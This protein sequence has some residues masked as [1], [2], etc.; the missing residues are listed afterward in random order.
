M[1]HQA[2]QLVAIQQ[3][4]DQFLSRP[5][6]RTTSSSFIMKRR[7]TRSIEDENTRLKEMLQQSLKR[8]L[9]GLSKIKHLQEMYQDLLYRT[10]SNGED[11]KQYQLNCPESPTSRGGMSSPKL[12]VVQESAPIV[13]QS[14]E[15]SPGN[16]KTNGGSFIF[17][18]QLSP[19]PSLGATGGGGSATSTLAP[20][21]I[22]LRDVKQE[23]EKPPTILKEV[24]FAPEMPS[25]DVK[26]MSLDQRALNSEFSKSD[27]QIQRKGLERSRS[28]GDEKINVRQRSGSFWKRRPRPPPE[29]SNPP[30]DYVDNLF[31]NFKKSANIKPDPLSEYLGLH[32]S[33]FCTDR[34]CKSREDEKY[35]DAVWELFQAE[36]KYLTKQLQPLEQVYKGFLEELHFHRV[37]EEAKIEKI[38]ANLS[39]L[40]ELSSSIANDL[41]KLFEGRSQDNVALPN[42][43]VLSFS[44]F[45]HKFNPVYKTFCTNFEQQRGYIKSLEKIPT[46][47][48]YLRLC[49]SS[50]SVQRSDI[51]DLLI[52]PMQHQCHYQLLLDNVLKHT[53]DPNHRAV[54][55]S[56]IKAFKVSLKELESAIAQQRCSLELLELSEMIY[57]P[58]VT[59]LSTESFIPQ[60]LM[61]HIREQPSSSLLKSSN[62]YLKL[63]ETFKLLDSRGRPYSDVQLILLK[64][65]LLIAEIKG[66]PSKK[67]HP[68][69]LL[70]QPFPPN[71]IKIHL[72]PESP[73]PVITLLCHST[74]GQQLAVLSL[75]S[76]GNEER[77]KWVNQLTSLGAKEI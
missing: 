15:E 51:N 23:R 58:P 74:L 30:S 53:T 49:R 20:I 39:E 7:R 65:L 2:D 72:P 16:A 61:D 11:S 25:D 29:D 22:L 9:D 33:V 76:T 77:S 34:N 60:T 38:F 54:L 48:D 45:G 59:Q 21:P 50:P 17:T 4:L 32:W 63:Q 26:S 57:W 31:Q 67:T 35:R 40:C 14:D 5:R 55:H 28:N 41:L 19:T 70:H 36:T 8:E 66:Q 68:Y 27:E 43:L 71:C 44:M 62:C 47:H 42:E 3:S 6:S 73:R 12:V 37:L 64:D 1:E 18:K 52:A 56:T 13:N 46:Y 10:H 75:L 24:T 69:H